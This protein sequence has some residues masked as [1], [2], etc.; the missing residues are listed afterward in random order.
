MRQRTQTHAVVRHTRIAEVE[1]ALRSAD[2]RAIWGGDWSDE[3]LL[4]S[5]RAQQEALQMV[6]DYANC[7]PTK[8]TVERMDLEP[9]FKGTVAKV[10]NKEQCPFCET[11]T[12]RDWTST[13]PGLQMTCPDCG[14]SMFRKA[15]PIPDT[16]PALRMSLTQINISN[17]TVI[18]QTVESGRAQSAEQIVGQFLGD[19]ITIDPSRGAEWNT[20][21]LKACGGTHASVAAFYACNNDLE[22][23]AGCPYVYS[24]GTQRW[25]KFSTRWYYRTGVKTT[26][27]ALI[28]GRD[29][30]EPFYK[31]L[32]AYDSADPETRK[33]RQ[34]QIR[35]VM[36]DMEDDRFQKAV[37][38]QLEKELEVT[39]EAFD[40]L[41]DT[42]PDILQFDDGSYD[43]RTDTFFP[44]GRREWFQSKSVGY[45]YAE[46]TRVTP[47]QDKEVERIAAE[48][49][50]DDEQR[51]YTQKALG[52]CVSGHLNHRAHFCIGSGGNGKSILFGGTGSALGEYAIVIDAA[53]FTDQLANLEAPSPQLMRIKGTRLV[54]ITEWN[55]KTLEVAR[56]KNYVGG[57]K[58]SGRNLNG[59]PVV[60]KVMAKF[61]VACNNE[62]QFEGSDGGVVRRF[63]QLNFPVRFVDELDPVEE[64]AA[65]KGGKK[66][67][68]QRDLTLERR[69]EEELRPAMMKWLLAGYRLYKA[70]GLNPPK[71][72][73]EATAQGLDANNSVLRFLEGTCEIGV[74][75]FVEGATL[76]GLYVAR[77]RDKMSPVEFGRQMGALRKEGRALYGKVTS[78]KK[79]GKTVYVGLRL[80][81]PEARLQDE[82][83]TSTGARPAEAERDEAAAPTGTGTQEV[84]VANA[85]EMEV[86][87]L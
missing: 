80:K 2:A 67:L 78:E 74:G 68:R 79:G 42:N 28:R 60:F 56:F 6:S 14:K 62:I 4:L 87:A 54:L 7:S 73:V 33:A 18:N 25:A 76:H 48:I 12:R 70:E 31:A 8:V 23:P 53:I 15:I 84:D 19:G 58:I 52:L 32:A 38:S 24:I 61:F 21:L 9:G 39:P 64:A 82:T 5:T 22:S 29:A 77:R 41:L 46:V 34:E 69:F 16:Y 75:G 44:G 26:P 10:H 37:V 35:R 50:P 71:A 65:V 11:E 45:D 63:C 40:D 81:G 3:V 36:T 13:A 72:V 57:E 59:N 1:V 27:F 85:V 20:R 47:E 49:V 55:K 83:T 17:L 66:Y 43:L 51:R 30:L 86:D